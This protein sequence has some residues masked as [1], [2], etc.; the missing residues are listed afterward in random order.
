MDGLLARLLAFLAALAFAAAARAENYS[1]IWYNP[2]E[3]G[4][5][6]TLA[7]HET[8]IFGVWYTYRPDGA[9]VWYTIPGGTF[10]QG[11]RIFSG[12]I[13]QTSGPA[14]T[15]AS[16]NPAQVQV[17]KVGSAQIDFSPPGYAAGTALFTF[18]I[19]AVSKTRPVVRQSFG[20][21]APSWG[22][23]VT[24]IWYN[25]A[26]S[27]WGMTLAQHGNNVF[28]VWFTYDVDGQPLWVVMPG[29]TFSGAGSFSGT[30]YTTRGP[31]FGEATFDS[32]RVVVT[33]AGWMSF[34]FQ[35]GALAKA[36]PTRA[37]MNGM[38]RNA[39]TFRTIGRQPFGNVAPATG[40]IQITALVLPNAHPGEYY[41]QQAATA[42]GG[43]PPYS[44]YA[45]SFANGA[46]PLGMSVEINGWLSGTPSSTYTSERDF[47]FGICVKD[48][49]GNRVCTPTGIRVSP[50]MSTLAWTVGNQCDNGQ[51]VQYKFY[52]YPDSSGSAEGVWPSATTHY[53]IN[54]GESHTRNL[55]C[56]KGHLV[57]IGARSSSGTLTWGVGFDGSGGCSGCCA[58]CNGNSTSYTFGCGTSGGTRYYANWHCTSSG[59]AAAMGGS[60]GSKGPFCSLANCNAWGQQYIPGLYTCS[61]TPTY[62]PSPGGTQCY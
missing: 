60:A 5:G 53:P 35:Q 43:S 36:F 54:F 4:W 58:T 45:D 55:S 20:N 46:P 10:S 17:W 13:Y 21:A 59:C 30:L 34:T 50:G 15:S 29:V 40:P 22:S 44:Y 3:S 61:T 48:V 24:D 42:A 38:F 52:Q 31:Y 33:Q 1:D 32:S 6:L 51:W 14:Y 12:D 28:G 8:Q 26:E 47:P 37:D 41:S 62:T 19:G 39:Q 2:A 9:P 18:T 7:D 11:R 23:D 57:C 56:D 27:G 25:A 49:G 16:F